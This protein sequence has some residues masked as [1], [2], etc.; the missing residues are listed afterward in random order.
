MQLRKVCCHPYLF[1]NVEPA[2]APPIGE[3]LVT[4]SGKMII[5]D[6][7]LSKLYK[8]GDH[9]ALIFSQMTSLLDIFEDFCHLRGY[10]YCR[11]DGNTDMKSR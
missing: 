4:S 11:I 3:H 1:P 2:D 7:L 9:K 10:T 6:K 8:E 5:L